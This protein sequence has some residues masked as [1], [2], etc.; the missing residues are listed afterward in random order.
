M[1][2]REPRAPPTVDRFAHARST[3]CR[4]YR[5]TVVRA[6]QKCAGDHPPVRVSEVH[7]CLLLRRTRM[8]STVSTPCRPTPL[9]P[10]F[11]Q[12]R[13]HLATGATNAI[14]LSRCL[15][16]AHARVAHSTVQ[17][18]AEWRALFDFVTTH[19]IRRRYQ[20]YRRRYRRYGEDTKIPEIM[21]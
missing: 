19:K 11:L 18:S 13:D 12:P 3:T 16:G 5:S 1:S 17:I 8:P 10:N 14:P 2:E 9:L 7:H 4:N 15:G 6:P 20:R 21:N